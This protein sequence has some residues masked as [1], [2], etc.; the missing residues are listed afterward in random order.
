MSAKREMETRGSG[1]GEH[2]MRIF[3]QRAEAVKKSRVIIGPRCNK[4]YALSTIFLSP[5]L[6]APHSPFCCRLCCCSFNKCMNW[7]MKICKRN[8]AHTHTKCDVFA[9]VIVIVCMSTTNDEGKNCTRRTDALLM[10]I[11]NLTKIHSYLCAEHWKKYSDLTAT[12]HLNRIF[13]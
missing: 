5:I 7:N 1:G 12:R 2:E 9:I 4:Y 8:Y 6:H 13:E 3:M 10:M 11:I